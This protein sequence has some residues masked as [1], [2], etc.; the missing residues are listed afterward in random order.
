MTLNIISS[1]QCRPQFGLV[2]DSGETGYFSKAY[3]C[4]LCM[5]VLMCVVAVVVVVVGGGGGGGGGGVRGWCV[6]VYVLV[7]VP[8]GCV[9]VLRVVI[10]CMCM[11]VW[12]RVLFLLFLLLCVCALAA[13]DVHILFSRNIFRFVYKF[14]SSFAVFS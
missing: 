12:M 2:K 10:V 8:F 3:E 11:S 9:S 7:R 5:C 13:V 6:L 1:M 14:E 4:V